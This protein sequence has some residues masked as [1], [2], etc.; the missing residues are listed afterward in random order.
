L[1]HECSRALKREE[2]S[3]FAQTFSVLLT[4]KQKF[5][6]GERRVGL[7]EIIL[8]GFLVRKKGE[9]KIKWRVGVGWV[10]I[11]TGSKNKHL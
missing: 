1:T 9:K 10:T 11:I 4:L 2:K 5:D 7:S 6:S 3:S 8:G